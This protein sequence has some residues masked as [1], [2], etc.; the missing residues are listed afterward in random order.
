MPILQVAVVSESKNI[1]VSD[2][3][4]VS[5]ALQ[6]QIMRDFAPIWGVQATV[7]PFASLEDV[8]LGYWPSIIQDNVKD[9]AGGGVHRD[10]QGQ[11]FAL[12]EFDT[13]WS[14]TTSHECLEMLADP[15]GSRL[16][17][18]PS[19]KKGQSRVEYLVE[20]CD[21]CESRRFAYTVNGVTVSDFY[22]PAFFDPV[23]APGVRY[24]FTGAIAAPRHVLADGYISWHY[25]VTNDWWQRLFFGKKR[26]RN[27]GPLTQRRG[28]LR[29]AI[30]AVTV[31]PEMREKLPKND[32]RLAPFR[33]ARGSANE[34]SVA[35]AKS[36][37]K[38]IESLKDAPRKTMD[39]A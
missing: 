27:L 4:Q 38:L 7:D 20:V 26:F 5:A 11:P 1:A 9:L 39:Y 3:T 8:P 35:R 30:D 36:L 24:S 10:D 25:P 33:D 12:V 22:T 14:L 29:S 37:R 28:S 2:L 6:K 31:D 21:P 15:F 19:L 16:I 23:K 32:A 17:A 34:S 18:G 13:E